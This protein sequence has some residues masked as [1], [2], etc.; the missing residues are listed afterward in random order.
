MSLHPQIIEN[1]GRKEF[2]V[3]PDEEFAAARPPVF[4]PLHFSVSV[5]TIAV[6]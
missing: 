6:G 1:D 5:F 3:L 2:V 4:P